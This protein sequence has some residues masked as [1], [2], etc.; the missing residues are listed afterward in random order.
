MIVSILL[1]YLAENN[2]VEIITEKNIIETRGLFFYYK[3]NYFFLL[4]LQQL[5]A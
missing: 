5:Y 3:K 1:K 4:W 2:L